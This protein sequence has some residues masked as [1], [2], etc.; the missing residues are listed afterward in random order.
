M[1]EIGIHILLATLIIEGFTCAV[2]ICI[3]TRRGQ[4]GQ[5]TGLALLLVLICLMIFVAV[6]NALQAGQR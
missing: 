6:P 5:A 4:K 2:L 1:S 3:A